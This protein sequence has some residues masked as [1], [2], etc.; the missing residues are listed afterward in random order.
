MEK[1]KHK[2]PAPWQLGKHTSLVI[3]FSFGLNLLGLIGAIYMM[4]VY[5]RV[6]SSGSVPTLIGLSIIAFILY[7]FYGGL[8]YLRT[9]FLT[10]H[11]ENF[12]NTYS[13]KAFR[14]AINGYSREAQNA[15]SRTAIEDL[16]T[17]RRFLTSKGYSAIFDVLWLPIFLIFIFSL[18][19]MLGFTALFA[20]I[21]L[22]TMAIINE[23][24]AR[25]RIKEE[26][27]RD[28]LSRRWLGNIHRNAHL[29][30]A[31][32]MDEAMAKIWIKKEQA[33][34]VE[35]MGFA[36][37]ASKF[38][39][40]S[41]TIRMIIQSMILGLGG[42]FAI[43]GAISPGAM[44]AAS[45]VFTRTIAPVEQLLVNFA[46]LIRA[47]QAWERMKSWS[48]KTLIDNRMALPAPHKTL[49]GTFKALTPP[50]LKKP[51]LTNVQ[52]ELKAGDV[53]GVLGSSGGGK[54]SLA[55]ALAGAW[56]VQ[57]GTIA[58]DGADYRDWPRQ[59]L[60]AAIGYMAQDCELFD[61]SI[62]ENICGFKEGVEDKDIVQ[63]AMTAG[64]H[65]IILGLPRGYN[66]PVG[67]TGVPLSTGQRQRLNLA[68]AL[69]GNPF[70]VV[71]DEPNSNLDE[72]G[73]NALLRAIHYLK[74]N[75]K[76]VIIVAHR[77]KALKHANKL[78][79]IEKGAMRLFGPTAAVMERLQ[80]EQQA[81]AKPSQNIQSQ[82]IKQ[83][84]SQVTQTKA[85]TAQ[86]SLP[87][88]PEQI[89][90]K[91]ATPH[92]SAPSLANNA[93]QPIATLKPFKPVV[94]V[95]NQE[96]AN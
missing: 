11:G 18:H 74:Q 52:I 45:I 65:D 53:L 70:I 24:N 36:A 37:R 32:G 47:Q 19:I 29:V 14:A 38:S 30:S 25:Q 72:D 63:A 88:R 17:I 39:V 54:S 69:F 95:P 44:I 57:N 75:N 28:T 26:S 81:N 68:R 61:G 58:M 92:P 49:M 35:S 94:D 4:Q 13:L 59:Q 71:L 83:Q 93:L 46:L 3:L 51:V 84:T 56:S 91:A 7:L 48:E 50:G 55:K 23:R 62:A 1:N 8:D 21:L 5:D 96:P 64:T 89:T 9:I 80:Q 40:S 66:T 79:I 67:P 34:R 20:T 60:G 43:Q 90:V 33:N 27:Q 6:L 86:P 85:S 76:I 10:T 87:P 15:D 2:T 12:S 82:T 16:T 78:C 42:Y 73:E 31:N 41:K 77:R 22:I